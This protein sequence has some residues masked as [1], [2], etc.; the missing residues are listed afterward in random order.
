MDNV[1]KPEEISSRE[2]LCFALLELSEMYCHHKLSVVGTPT[3]N[4]GIIY[5]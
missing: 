5:I 3:V 2:E 4:D 1:I